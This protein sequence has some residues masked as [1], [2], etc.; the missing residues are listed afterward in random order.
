[1]KNMALKWKV[2]LQFKKTASANSYLEKKMKNMTQIIYKKWIN[3]KKWNNGK[4]NKDTDNFL[5]RQ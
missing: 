4:R 3:I 5:S 1:L 2:M